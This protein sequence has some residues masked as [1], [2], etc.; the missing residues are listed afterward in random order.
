MPKLL[1]VLLWIVGVGILLL[2]AF[3]YL[4]SEFLDGMFI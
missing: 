3:L 2:I 4:L 1:K